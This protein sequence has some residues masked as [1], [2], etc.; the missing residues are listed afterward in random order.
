MELLFSLY[1]QTIKQTNVRTINV[2]LYVRIVR[3]SS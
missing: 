3:S 2:D 1:L